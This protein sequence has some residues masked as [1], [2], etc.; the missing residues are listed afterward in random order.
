MDNAIEAVKETEEKTVKL[1]VEKQ[2]GVL[3]ITVSNSK[4]AE[5]RPLE[6]DFKTT[7]KDKK[8]HGLGSRIVRD[9]V[10]VHGGRVSYHDEGG[11]MRVV[12]LMQE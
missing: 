8:N 7:K 6:N 3:K 10:E 1:S 5:R 2:Q 4:L 12:A 9:I 11:Q